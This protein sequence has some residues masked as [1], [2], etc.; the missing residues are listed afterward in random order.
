MTRSLLLFVMS[1]TLACCV[2]GCGP[3]INLAMLPQEPLPAGWRMPEGLDNCK[4]PW[5]TK[6]PMIL[7]GGKLKEI[8]GMTDLPN[9]TSKAMF[10]VYLNEDDD[11]VMIAFLTFATPDD[12]AEFYNKRQ[13]EAHPDGYCE[14]YPSVPNTLILLVFDMHCPDRDFFLNYFRS[15]QDARKTSPVTNTTD[16]GT[17]SNDIETLN[18]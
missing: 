8:R 16:D 4:M 5:L 18:R 7:T 17:A 12:A 9:S 10:A 15:T 2:A 11:G 1:V 13:E 6:N 3:Q 14:Y